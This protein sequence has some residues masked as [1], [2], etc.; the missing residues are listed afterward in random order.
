[1]NRLICTRAELLRTLAAI[2]APCSVKAQGIYRRPPRPAFEGRKC[3]LKLPSQRLACVE[4]GVSAL[5][6]AASFLELEALSFRSAV[7]AT[8]G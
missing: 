3:D 4:D 1:M 8:A 5:R 7:P 2:R 6:P